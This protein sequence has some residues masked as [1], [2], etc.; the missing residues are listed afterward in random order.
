MAHVTL[1]ENTLHKSPTNGLTF[2]FRYKNATTFGDYKDLSNLQNAA[3]L[4]TN[5]TG[6]DM[7]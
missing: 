4:C 7:R 6:N 1:K 2:T 3:S 5:I